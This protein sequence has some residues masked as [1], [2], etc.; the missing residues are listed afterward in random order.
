MKVLKSIFA[1]SLV[2]FLCLNAFAGKQGDITRKGTPGKSIGKD[3]AEQAMPV[4][5]YGWWSKE[6]KDVIKKSNAKVTYNGKDIQQLSV[7][8]LIGIKTQA[9]KANPKGGVVNGLLIDGN[10]VIVNSKGQL[11][12]Q[13]INNQPVTNATSRPIVWYGW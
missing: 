13:T 6:T 9:I 11:I 5:W 12:P 1:F 8:E 2:S 3:Q 4:V 7:Q 10:K